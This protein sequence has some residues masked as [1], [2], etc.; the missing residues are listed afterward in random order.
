MLK[1]CGQFVLNQ[2]SKKK[3]DHDLLIQ[4]IK[5]LM[6]SNGDMSEAE[7]ARCT[8]I[9]KTTVYKILS[10]ETTDPRY[11]TLTQI[12]NFFNVSL[13]E[14]TGLASL[15]SQRRKEPGKII[16]ILKWSDIIKGKSFISSLS[17][18]N[19]ENWVNIDIEV[20]NG[21]ALMSRPSMR[22]RFPKGTIFIIDPNL[23]PEDGDYVIINY[24]DSDEIALR[25]ISIDGKIIQLLAF[26]PTSSSEP[27]NNSIKILGVLVQSR[28]LH[29]GN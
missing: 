20:H 24:K 15:E 12:A 25:E 26:D 6:L 27:L 11:S 17:A 5:R 2:P 10:G 28:F 4:S 16:P 3:S 23:K 8:G 22:S 13:D 1:K 18:N 21:Y 29:R 14:L 7:L 19:W 9:P